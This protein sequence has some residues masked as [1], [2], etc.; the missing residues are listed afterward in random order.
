M[1]LDGHFNANDEPALKLDLISSFIQVL[2][3]TGFAGSLIIPHSE[4]KNLALNF[5]GF[6]EFY[7]VTGH[8]FVAPA[9]SL[10]INWLGEKIK[11]AIATSPEVTEALLGAQMLKN[12]RLTIDYAKRTVEVVREA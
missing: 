3:D 10:E 12:C 8:V 5:E 4:A 1:P 2:I 11:V 9:Y 6:E 7:T